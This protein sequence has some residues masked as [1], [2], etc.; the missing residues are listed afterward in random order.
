MMKKWAGAWRYDLWKVQRSM[1]KNE[2]D[3]ADVVGQEEA[4]EALKEIADFLFTIRKYA[5]IGATSAEDGR[6][7]GRPSRN[8]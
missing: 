1:R 3:F 6:A 2:T 5:D 7:F 4:K 8:W